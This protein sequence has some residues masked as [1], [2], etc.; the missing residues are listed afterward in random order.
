MQVHLPVHESSRDQE[1]LDGIDPFVLDDQFIAVNREHFNDAVVG[2]DA[3]SD[4]GK[5]AV[6]GQVIEP[7]HVELAGN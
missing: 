4:T 2:D 5:K 3:F 1:L 6:A 7:V